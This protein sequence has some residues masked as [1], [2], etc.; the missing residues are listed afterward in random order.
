MPRA[1]LSVVV[2]TMATWAQA[3]DWPQ[4]YGPQRN[5]VSS[6]TDLAATWPVGGPRELWAFSLGP[7]YCGV[8][9]QGGKVYLLDREQEKQEIVRCLDLATGREDWNFAYDAPAKVTWEGSRSTPSV[10]D[11]CVFTVGVT[12]EILCVDKTTHK[13]RWQK[14]I[15]TLYGGKPP[16]FSVSQSPLLY[17]DMVIVAPQSQQ[18]CLSALKKSDGLEVWRSAPLGDGMQYSSPVLANLEG[19]DQVVLLKREGLLAVDLATGTTLWTYKG[20][21]CWD[22]APAPVHLGGGRFFINGSGA[23]GA[24][25]QVSRAGEQWQLTGLFKDKALFDAQVQAAVPYQGYLYVNGNSEKKDRYGLTCLDFEGH[26]QW[27]TQNQPS[28]ELGS[29]VIANG[30]LYYMDGKSGTLTMAQAS[31]AG[32]H[33]LARAKVL[34]A[35]KGMCWASLAISDGKLLCRDQK[36]LKCLDIRHP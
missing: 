6:E 29:L 10:D 11:T 1:I 5:G 17:K 34:T 4:F 3:A 25:F 23:G 22:P 27:Q 24:F 9:V 32:Y 15:F 31:P 14:N 13:P 33:E 35:A 7:G 18:A 21:D 26:M 28:I 2:L 12:G 8:A 19:V 30:L 20:Q 16:R 36:E